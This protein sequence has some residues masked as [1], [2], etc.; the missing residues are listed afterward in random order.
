MRTTMEGSILAPLQF[1]MVFS[2]LVCWR[3]ATEEHGGDN[4]SYLGLIGK[5]RVE[6]IGG[7]R[8]ALNSWSPGIIRSA[9][10]SRREITVPHASAIFFEKRD[11]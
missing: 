6:V 7:E 5:R 10:I 8:C 3:C 4:D 2:M 11:P 9:P 1:D